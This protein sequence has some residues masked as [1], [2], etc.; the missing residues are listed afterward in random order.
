MIQE[1]KYFIG[2]PLAPH[3]R[4][5]V[6]EL[7]GSIERE[8]ALP[9]TKRI[10]AHLT[11]VPPFLT[12]DIGKV[13]IV[14]RHLAGAVGTFN[15]ATAGYGSFDTHTWYVGL[16]RS[17]TLLHMKYLLR[18]S[19]ENL[20]IALP[21][22]LGDDFHVSVAV[23]VPTPELHAEIGAFLKTYPFPKIDPLHFGRLVIYRRDE[24]RWNEV[25]SSQLG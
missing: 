3:E 13:Q 12:A 22:N 18:A 23:D 2:M 15:V 4:D 14:L 10:D 7:R 6:E 16:V 1:R 17:N 5:A 11:L 19:I 25:F 24:H 9:Q 21:K 20:G 8:F